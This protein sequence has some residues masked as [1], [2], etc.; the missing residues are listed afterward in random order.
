[1]TLI[2]EHVRV[3]YG[4]NTVLDDVSLAARDAQVTALIGSNGAGKTTLFNV[5]TGVRVPERGTVRLDDVDLRR[6]AV[7]RRVR[8]GLGR[9]FQRLELF[10]S[11]T[12][13]ENLTVAASNVPRRA[14]ARSVA[15]TI[16]RLGLTHLADERCATLP[17][18]TGRLVELGRAL[19]RNPKVLLLDEPASGQ[20]APETERFSALLQELATEGL[21]ILLV[22][23]DMNLVM[24]TADVVHVLD[25]GRIIASGPP[26]VIRADPH[27]QHAYLG[28]EGAA[29]KAG[30]PP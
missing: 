20:T 4:G 18:G 6:H 29:E 13:A 15:A 17:T 28:F 9:T 16:D 7:H 1:M 25:A 11:L 22:E 26:E 3:V 23:H 12:V 27:V 5:I 14:R 24:R 21:A 2:V 19:V 10:D 8:E 30:A